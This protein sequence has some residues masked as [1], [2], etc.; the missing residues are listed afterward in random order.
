MC[1]YSLMCF[2]NRLAKEHEDL[3]VHRFASGSLG[4]ASPDELRPKGVAA[5]QV[6]LS[7]WAALKRFFEEECAPTI[8][9]VCIPPSARIQLHDIDKDFRMKYHVTAE[10]EVTFEQMSGN[11]NEYRDAIRFSNGCRVRLQELKP[12][13]RVTV[14]TLGETEDACGGFTRREELVG[15]AA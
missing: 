15:R 6:R 13:Q 10:E 5:A 14:L 9:A 7:F 12:G 11:A 8:T 1:D 2:P 4:L 3:V